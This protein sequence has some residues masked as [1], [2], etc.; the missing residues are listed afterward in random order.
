V[1]KQIKREYKVK[2]ER[3][4]LTFMEMKQGLKILREAQEKGIWH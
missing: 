3:A 1:S 2:A 4:R